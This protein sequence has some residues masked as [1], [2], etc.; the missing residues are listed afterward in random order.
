MILLSACCS[1]TCADQPTTRLAAK[2][3]VKR[4]FGTPR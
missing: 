1:S 4:S 3:G 2:S